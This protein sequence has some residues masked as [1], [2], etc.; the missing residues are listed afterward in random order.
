METS[1]IITLINFQMCLLRKEGKTPFHP[2]LQMVEQ[3]P[4][5]MVILPKLHIAP[6]SLLIEDSGRYSAFFHVLV[7]LERAD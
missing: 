4:R 6:C 7:M 5:K 3:C 1:L 2:H